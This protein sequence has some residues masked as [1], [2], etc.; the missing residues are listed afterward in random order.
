MLVFITTSLIGIRNGFTS[1]EATVKCHRQA[2]TILCLAFC[3][4][5]SL[6]F[7][8]ACVRVSLS[9]SFVLFLSFC[10]LLS[11]FVYLSVF[12]SHYL[13]LSPSLSFSLS[14]PL[15]L[16]RSHSLCPYLFFT[17]TLCLCLSFTIS[18]TI[19]FLHSLSPSA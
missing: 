9:L 17:L 12:H 18:L 14:V 11:C 15:P 16:F 19:S 1:I 2:P 6:V 10:L 13:C 5:V 8:V 3:P 4:I 7:S